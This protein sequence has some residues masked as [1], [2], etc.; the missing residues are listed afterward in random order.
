MPQQNEKV[1][2]ISTSLLANPNDTLINT[3]TDG[4][5]AKQPQR[6]IHS[7]TVTYGFVFL[8]WPL[9]HDLINQHTSH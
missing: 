2:H 7:N 5:T 3:A 8:N 4:K 9:Q 6:A 1:L